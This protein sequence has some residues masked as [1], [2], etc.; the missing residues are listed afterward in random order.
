MVMPGVMMR[1]PR[2][3]RVPAGDPTALTVCQPIS[4]AITVVLLLPVAIF[5]AIRNKSGL[6]AAQRKYP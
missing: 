5:R 4:I 3:N 2:L 6:R 1:K